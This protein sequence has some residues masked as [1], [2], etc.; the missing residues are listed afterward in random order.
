MPSLSR[1]SR[2]LSSSIG[3]TSTEYG[4]LAILLLSTIIA[5]SKRKRPNY[6]PGPKGWPIV[7]SALELDPGRPWIKLGE[8]SKQYGPLMMVNN[9]GAPFIIIGS[10]KVARDLLVKRANVTSDRPR[11]VM[12]DELI[13]DKTN[14]ALARTSYGDNMRKQ[15]RVLNDQLRPQV[16]NT[17]GQEVELQECKA[18]L[19]GIIKTPSSFEQEIH[20]FSASLMLNL[21]YDH[22]AAS[23]DDPVVV[24]I[25]VSMQR[26]FGAFVPGA[27]LVDL[28][29]ALRFV[30]SWFP[31]ADFK[32]KAKAW[33]KEDQQLYT[34]LYDDVEDRLKIN[35]ARACL[36]S[37]MQET[38]SK[39]GL[40]RLEMSCIAGSLFAAGTDT[41]GASILIWVVAM[42]HFPEVLKKAQAEIDAVVGRERAPNFQDRAQLPYINAMV[43]ENWRWRAAAPGSLPH[44]LEQDEIYEGYFLPKGSTVVALVHEMNNDAEAFSEPGQFRPERFL[45]EDGTVNHD[46][47]IYTFG[48]G[49]RVCPGYNLADASLFITISNLAWAFNIE[50]PIDEKKKPIL[51][52]LDPAR[53]LASAASGP[54]HFE[55]RFTP[56][57]PG[58]TDIIAKDD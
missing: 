58:V 28:F 16:V 42:L 31:G 55:A 20:R 22:F 5:Y 34:E 46:L 1:L 13:S 8:W 26:L 25:V 10:A 14:P 23:M 51:P 54:C 37:K 41:T 49:R 56:R 17:V 39:T 43:R 52:D 4:F 40:S 24:K 48:H 44:R 53:W 19:R 30:P 11:Q 33:R 18:L 7:G 3:F 45:K 15:R 27:Y 50:T 9:F 12:A 57:F 38:Q 29:P 36:V 21:I 47:E 35:S 2:D 32:R 6:P